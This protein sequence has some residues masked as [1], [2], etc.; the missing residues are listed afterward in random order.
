MTSI[1]SY[2]TRQKRYEGETG[3]VF[4]TD[5]EFDQLT[6]F[7]GYTEFDGHRYAATAQQVE[8]NT[9][10]VIDPAGV[11]YFMN[12]YHGDKNVH[13]V[14]VRTS[15]WTRFRRMKQRDGWKKAIKRIIYDAKAFAGV[16]QLADVIID[17]N[18]ELHVAVSELLTYIDQYNQ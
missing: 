16:E 4:V 10:Y 11:E 18:D 13:V 2:T 5:E 15:A 14:V 1:E 6:D 7:V 9:F 17:N 8:E 12:H 3:H